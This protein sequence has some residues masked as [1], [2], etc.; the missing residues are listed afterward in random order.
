M[1]PLLSV[2]RLSLIE[3][4]VALRPLLAEGLPL[5]WATHYSTREDYAP[6]PSRACTWVS[7]R[8]SP[9]RRSYV[10]YAS[11][12]CRVRAARAVHRPGDIER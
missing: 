7:T 12:S 2:A 1:P 9:A 6:P 10:D 4:S 3:R 8:R 11:A 5:S